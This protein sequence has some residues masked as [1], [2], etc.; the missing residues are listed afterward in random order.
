MYEEFF[1]MRPIL[2]VP[3]NVLCA[4]LANDLIFTSG[5]FDWKVDS[6]EN[7]EEFNKDTTIY[8][9]EMH[10]NLNLP[11]FVVSGTQGVKLKRCGEE[12]EMSL[13]KNYFS[14]FQE[15]ISLSTS[16]NVVQFCT[17]VAGVGV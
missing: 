11:S 5:L 1:E 6:G 8:I 9:Y 12:S 14:L 13:I 4:L 2:F 16:F 3:R 15:S 7:F 10:S 17:F